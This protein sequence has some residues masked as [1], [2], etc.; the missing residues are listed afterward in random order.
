MDL[1]KIRHMSTS[2]KG[3]NTLPFRVVLSMTKPCL[4]PRGNVVKLLLFYIM[5]RLNGT[6]T[7]YK[8]QEYTA[9]FE[10]RTKTLF[11]I[12]IGDNFLTTAI[13]LHLFGECEIK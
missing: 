5:E 13:K 6:T 3:L 10:N 11:P 4:V 7:D 9:R 2:T 8:D 1:L 12:T